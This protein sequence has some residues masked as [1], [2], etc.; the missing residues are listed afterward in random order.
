MALT[1]TT[2]AWPARR[3]AATRSATDRMRS[4]EPTLVPPYFWTI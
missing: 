3:V 2:T 1:T 4:V